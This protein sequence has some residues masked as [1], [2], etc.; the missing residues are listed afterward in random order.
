MSFLII[1]DALTLVILVFWKEIGF[2]RPNGPSVNRV[3]AI[4]L[5]RP[6]GSAWFQFKIISLY[7]L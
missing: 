6:M 3:K 2:H 1:I 4:F 5:S 7:R